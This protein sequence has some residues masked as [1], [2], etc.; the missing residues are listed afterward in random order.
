M[1]SK[2]EVSIYFMPPIAID[3]KLGHLGALGLVFSGIFLNKKDKGHRG[4]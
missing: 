1:S 3:Y 4:N 2:T